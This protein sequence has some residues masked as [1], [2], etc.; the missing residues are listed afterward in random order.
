MQGGPGP[1]GKQG[2][3]GPIGQQ[4]I[5]GEPG[6]PGSPGLAVSDCFVIIFTNM[7]KNISFTN[8]TTN[9]LTA[10]TVSFQSYMFLN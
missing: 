3:R 1:D 2:Q 8:L 10:L 9:K 7:D 6:D 5:R 4:G